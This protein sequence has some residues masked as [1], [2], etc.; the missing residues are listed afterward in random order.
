MSEIKWVV[1]ANSSIAKIFCI[2]KF[3]HLKEISVL[4]HPESRLHNQDLVS[5]K[6]GRN[7]QSGGTTRHAYSPE[8]EPKQVE[9]EKFARVLAEHLTT[10][11]QQKD[12]SQLYL[13]SSPGFL[14]LLRPQLHSLTQG[15]ILGEFPIDLT[16]HTTEDIEK[17]LSKI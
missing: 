17:H 7:F 16:E 5:S 11:F 14:G 6:P 8:T 9:A 10:S 12:F 3:P 13:L 15:A 2:L 4:E 1:V